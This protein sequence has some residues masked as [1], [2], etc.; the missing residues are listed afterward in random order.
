M[1]LRTQPV[2]AEVGLGTWELN[3]GLPLQ[4]GGG[5]QA[6][7]YCVS[8]APRG[9]S[10]APLG[11]SAAPQGVSAA[12]RGV[13]PHQAGGPHGALAP[14]HWDWTSSPPSACQAAC[15]P[16]A[17]ERP[18]LAI[19]CYKKLREGYAEEVSEPFPP[20]SQSP[21]PAMTWD[22]LSILL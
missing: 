10:A 8:A 16:W 19:L 14:Q 7:S 6:A 4:G 21:S 1:S 9:V 18:G 22:V 15:H 3:P 17:T 20:F 5:E 12:P 11:V 2:Q 13:H